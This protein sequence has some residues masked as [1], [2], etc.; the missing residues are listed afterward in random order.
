MIAQ[1]PRLALKCTWSPSNTTHLSRG[2]GS[3]AV[4]PDLGDFG[5]IRPMLRAYTESEAHI[6]DTH[7]AR[8]NMSSAFVALG[9]QLNE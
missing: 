9:A 4:T 3:Y 8:E 6:D 7:A 2:C 1:S 5:A